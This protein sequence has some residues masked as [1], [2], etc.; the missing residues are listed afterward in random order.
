VEKVIWSKKSINSLNK[1]WEFYAKT[2]I[3]VADKIANEIIMHAESIV[4][5]GQY[6]NEEHLKPG[7]RR[8]VIRHFKIIY[9][10]KGKN[11]NKLKP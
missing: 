11:P 10:I 4:F 5:A 8:A 6:Q 1:V 2:N 3:D 7:Q 9:S